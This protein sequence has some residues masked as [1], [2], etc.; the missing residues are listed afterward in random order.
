MTTF[1]P[2]PAPP[3]HEAR[4][5]AIRRQLTTMAATR[6]RSRRPLFLV[7]GAV[8]V[9]IATS[10]GAYAYLPHSAPVT[11]KGQARCYTEASLSGGNDF[12]TVG[13]LVPGKPGPAAIDSAVSLCADLWRQGFLGL[14]ATSMAPRPDTSV[15]HQVPQLTACVLP[16][17]T[18]AVFPGPPST[19]Q[20]LS[21][22][23]AKP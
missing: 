21:L 2:P 12:T 10:A 22:P 15:R 1:S 11:D 16:D 19:C 5:D 13:Q 8:A 9:A 3:M 17:G 7:S 20:A 6:R 14:G 18:A 4:R 23:R